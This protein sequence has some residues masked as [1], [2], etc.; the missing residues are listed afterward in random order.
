MAETKQETQKDSGS[1]QQQKGSGNSS[2]ARKNAFRAAAIAAASGAT[3]VVARK[4]FTDRQQK[5]SPAKQQNGGSPGGSGG[6]ESLFSGVLGSGWSAARDSLLPFA[7]DAANAAGEYLGRSG[8]DFVRETIVP[9]F[10]DGFQNAQK[11]GD[12]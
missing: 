11:S 9:A 7:E 8:P 4:A 3:A 5:S 1:A 12:E 6:A 2:D 10:I